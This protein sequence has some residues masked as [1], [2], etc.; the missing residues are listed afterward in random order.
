MKTCCS[1]LVVEDCWP[2]KKPRVGGCRKRRSV[3][4]PILQPEPV[5]DAEVQPEPILDAEVQTEPVP[6][7]KVQPEPVRRRRSSVVGIPIMEEAKRI[8][9]MSELL[10]IESKMLTKKKSRGRK[11]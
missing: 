10:G 5:M 1:A 3:P 7:A 2:T 9:S 11:K 6:E 8:K 4:E